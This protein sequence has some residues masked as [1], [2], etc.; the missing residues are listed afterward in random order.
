MQKKILV[1]LVALSLLYA[2]NVGCEKEGPAEKAGKEVDRAL[3]S[4][5][6]NYK[7]MTK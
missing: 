7:K 4:A 3:D 1:I 2:L 5:K 6:D